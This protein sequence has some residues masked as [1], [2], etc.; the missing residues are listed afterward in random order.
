MPRAPPEKVAPVDSRIIHGRRREGF[1]EGF[2]N[3]PP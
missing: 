3:P 2:P 1:I